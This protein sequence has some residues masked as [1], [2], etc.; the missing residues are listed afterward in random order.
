MTPKFFPI[1]PSPGSWKIA[2]SA[3]LP[4]ETNIV[5]KLTGYVIAKIPSSAWEQRPTTETLAADIGNARMIVAGPVF[6]QM[7]LY[8][9]QHE[10]GL[11][12][13]ATRD[14]ANAILSSLGIRMALAKPTQPTSVPEGHVRVTMTD[15]DAEF[16]RG[17]LAQAALDSELPSRC[18]R[19]NRIV[20]SMGNAMRDERA[21]EAVQS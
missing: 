4:G 13:Q 17:V 16:V 3:V 5:S 2:Q 20:K 11:F 9:M 8:A 18:M 6:A 19:L 10:P 14:E 7:A 12:S 15:E 21:V 1:A